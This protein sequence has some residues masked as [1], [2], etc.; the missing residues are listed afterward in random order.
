MKIQ[1]SMNDEL[2]ARLDSFAKDSYLSRS[3]VCS[4]ALTQ[5][6]NANELTKAIREMSFAMRKIADTQT[7]DDDTRQQLADFERLAQ[8]L[9]GQK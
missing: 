2:A 7:V 9:T 5:Y 1:I 4:I 3:A 6:L 8:L